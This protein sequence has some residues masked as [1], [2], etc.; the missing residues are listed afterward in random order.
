MRGQERKTVCIFSGSEGRG[1]VGKSLEDFFLA[2]L[3]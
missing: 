2:D 1:K 3:S